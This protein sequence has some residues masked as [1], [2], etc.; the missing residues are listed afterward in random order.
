[1]VTYVIPAVGLT[2]GALFLDEP[3]DVRLLTGAA[4]I[5]GSIGICSAATGRRLRWRT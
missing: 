2:L 1:M 3:V 5:V 4:M